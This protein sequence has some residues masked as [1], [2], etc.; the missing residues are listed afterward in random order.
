MSE[1]RQCPACLS[2]TS[3]VLAAFRDGLPCPYCGLPADA[4]ANFA[5][6]QEVGVEKAIV[7]R[8]IAAEMRAVKAEARVVELTEILARVRE[9]VSDESTTQ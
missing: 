2:W 6:A 3:G 9:V 4:A 1:K 5:R 8:A 7:E